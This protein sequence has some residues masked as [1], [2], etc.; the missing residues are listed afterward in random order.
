M[1]PPP[2]AVDPTEKA[3]DLSTADGI[4]DLVKEVDTLEGRHKGH[5]EGGSA[6]LP[7]SLFI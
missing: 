2:F 1:V 3:A 7:G 5:R 6:R 4:G